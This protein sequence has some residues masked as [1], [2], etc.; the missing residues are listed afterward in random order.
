VWDDFQMFY[1]KISSTTF[2]MEFKI[3]KETEML[4]PTNLNVHYAKGEDRPPDSY[5][6]ESGK[7][8]FIYWAS[9][10]RRP[11]HIV[12]FKEL[13]PNYMYSRRVNYIDREIMYI[14]C[15]EFFDQSGRLW[16]GITRDI[17]LENDTGY[18]GENMIDFMDYLNSHRTILDS[19]G[20]PN[21]KWVGPEYSDIKF[22]TRK[23]K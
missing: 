8:M 2:P 12:E 23:A 4:F 13:D 22:L 19:K 20:I 3:V 5:V 1:Q 16:R 21:P 15:T 6:D 17:I 10:Q 9:Y 7:Q 11:I 14:L 18:Y